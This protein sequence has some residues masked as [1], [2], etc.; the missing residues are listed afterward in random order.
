[1]IFKQSRFITYL[2]FVSAC[3]LITACSNN[4]TSE[5]NFTGLKLN[6]L[7]GSALGDFCNQAAKNFNATQPK[8]D[9]G[10]AFQVTCKAMGSGDV[11]TEI[12]ALASQLQKGTVKADAP[13]FPTIIS[14]DGDI[15]H[16]Q[17][18]YRMN[19]L[20]PG[21]SYIP[22]ITES[23][24]IANTPMVFMAQ[25]DIASGLR[26]VADPYKA[27]VSAN[28]HRD[29]DSSA[30][31]LTV[32]Y[33]H[34]APTRSNSGL[35]T[36][37]AQYSS[38][39]GKR[40]EELSVGD[41]AKFQ[42]QIQQI[43]SKITRYGVSTNSLAQAMVKNG[44]FWAS[45]GSVYESSVIT[46]NSGLKQGQQRYEAVYP[47][48]TFTSNM[49]AI[50]PNAPWVSTDEKAAAEKFIVY[51]RS[52]E[53][54]KIA[55]DLGLRPGTPGVALGAKFTPEFGVDAQAKY[56]SLR[57]PEPEVV[58]AM[59]KSWQENAKKPSLVVVVVDSSGSMSG[60]KLPAVQN[61]LQTYVKN[62][63][64][65]EQIALIDFDSEIR[66]PVL[67]DGTP[68]G[69]DRG[70][71][72]INSLQAD[73][74]TKLYDAALEARNWLQKN[75]RKD[76]INA[77]LILTD[78]EDSGSTIKLNEL[79]QELKK[80]GFSTD[81]RIAFFTVGYGKEGEFSPDVLKQIA[82]LNGGYY[83]QG[84]PETISQLMSNLQVE[85]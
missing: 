9:N 22:E 81:Q 24:L 13:D 20:F 35:Q 77:V 66:P 37:V 75:L 18:I 8:L 39:S 14:L 63:G 45:V 54:Q 71:Q 16:S 29:I 73:G 31:P 57:P 19:Q 38:I 58:D 68:Q 11:V 56:D 30:P 85:F 25:A 44:P 51:W 61:T 4:S 6:L 26:K 23:Q 60:D 7:V 3:L 43:Q 74:G 69:R 17:L 2:I 28:T 78:G 46:A 42:P 67:V 70:W 65:K 64:P 10:T 83:S 76:A 41:V 27:L 80:S 53:V 84:N 52:P 55:T 32:H 82:E 33:V 47:K 1:M 21:K 59:L 12:V 40:P 5:D 79:E 34:S 15:Y 72:F 50:I 49:R 48:A 62:L 36:L